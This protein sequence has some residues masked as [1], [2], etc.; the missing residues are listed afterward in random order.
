MQLYSIQSFLVCVYVCVSVSVWGG[1]AKF[2]YLNTDI[3]YVTFL[4][5]ILQ[6]LHCYRF[7]NACY[8]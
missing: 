6:D 4:R 1:V 5:Y 3:S 7:C 2:Y 8:T